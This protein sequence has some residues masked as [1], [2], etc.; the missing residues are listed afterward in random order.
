MKVAPRYW[1]PMAAVVV[2][3]GLGCRPPEMG[4]ARERRLMVF[5]RLGEVI[6]ASVPDARILVVGNPFSRKTGAAPD[7]RH[8]ADDAL[9]GLKK[10]LGKGS[11]S[12]E[13]GYPE[14]KPGALDDPRSVD[15]P[16]GATT[17][18][19]FMTQPGA[20]DRLSEAHRGATVWVS[21]IGL[22]ADLASTRAWTEP[23]GPKWVL[24]LAD[25][26]MIGPGDAVAAALREG[27]LLAAVLARP[28]APAESKPLDAD[29]RAEFDA[30]Y[31]LLTK[32]RAS[33][34]AGAP[35]DAKR[36]SPPP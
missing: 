11:W 21:L 6:G 5:E 3:A 29:S 17:P 4:L 36:P 28:G 33:G 22:P 30:R 19:S 32:D 23:G 35:S 31:L 18:L 15:I 10:G 25:L 9:R 14:L 13:V 26:E 8:A 34:S 20:W 27:R 12:I 16:A 1:I 7:V 24:Y 2:A